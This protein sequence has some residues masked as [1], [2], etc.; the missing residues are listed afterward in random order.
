MRIVGYSDETPGGYGEYMRLTED[1]LIEVPN[2]LAAENAALAEPMAVGLH[3]VDKSRLDR[4]DVPL[5]IG[6]G[7][8]GL[9]VVAA[10]HSKGAHPIVAA[11]FSPKRR[12]LAE[13]LGADVV[14]DPA[15]NSPYETWK[16]VAVWR[17]PDAPALPPWLPGPPMRPSLIFE[18][19]GIPGMIDKIVS[20]ARPNTRIIV[21]GICMQ[22]DHLEPMIAINKELSLQF[23]VFYT[24]EE[25]A[26]SL[27]NIAEGR[28]P[29]QS[30]I[31]GRVRVDQISDAFS[32]LVSPETD[33]KILVNFNR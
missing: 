10:L 9:G 25:Y 24:P 7:P 6:C 1:L 28:I 19:V 2:G 27:R 20:S 30:L 3:A 4:N 18:C 16:S 33:A 29:V 15:V 5:V 21:V 14:V 17:G 26:T 12:R 8:I 31:S 32:R 11:D 22:R 13:E 23:V